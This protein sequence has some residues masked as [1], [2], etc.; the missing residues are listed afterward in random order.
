[1]ELNWTTFVL[2][3]INFLILL[4]ILKRFLYKPVLGAIAQRK[5]AIDKTLSDAKA[6]QD[7]AHALEQQYQNR[8][9][10]WQKEKDKLRTALVEEINAQRAQMMTALENSLSQERE[11]ARVLEQRRLEELQNRAEKEG[12]AKG[13]QFTARLLARAA[14]PE[15]EASLVALVLEDLPLLSDEQ[16][17]AIRAACREG[18]CRAKVI[19]AY[20]L[21][22]ELRSAIIQKLKVTTQD[23][24]AVEFSEDGRLLAGLRI[25][26]GPWVLRA[27]LQD[28]LEFFAETVRHDSRNQ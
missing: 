4:W 13:V 22:E 14:C 27:N 25:S 10:D 5:A 21:P 23:T 28:E 16:L 7:D 6:M 26:I 20:S 1:M 18:P 2:E 11:R 9:A 19:S 12:T 15:L 8:V 17:Q 24:I 3:V